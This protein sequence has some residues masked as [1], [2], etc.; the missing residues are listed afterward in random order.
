MCVR[1]IERR[2]GGSV[3]TGFVLLSLV[4]LGAAV[5]SADY[6]LPSHS[7]EV[8]NLVVIVACLQLVG[9]N[10]SQVD[11]LNFLP[12]RRLHTGLHLLLL[13]L[14]RRR[15]P[16]RLRF[17]LKRHRRAAVD[18]TAAAATTGHG[19]VVETSMDIA[20]A[21]VVAATADDTSSGG[22]GGRVRIATA[23]GGGHWRRSSWQDDGLHDRYGRRRWNDNR[24]QRRRWNTH[25]G[26][27]VRGG[28]LFGRDDWKRWRRLLLDVARN[29][30]RRRRQIVVIGAGRARLTSGL[31]LLLLSGQN[32]RRRELRRWLGVHRRNHRWRRLV[33]FMLDAVP[34]GV[35]ISRGVQH[36]I[37]RRLHLG[38]LRRRLIVVLLVMMMVVVLLRRFVWLCCM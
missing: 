35:R 30:H 36:R 7:D 17:L 29:H 6:V 25:D 18:A 23:T 13:R 27:G 37:V 4:V 15:L 2:L 28:V 11:L 19:L 9:R 34:V 10:K 16:L 8:H 38:W 12:N 3:S 1:C 32:V 26:R 21:A 14:N 5:R 33:E 20:T 31:L 22:H 24:W